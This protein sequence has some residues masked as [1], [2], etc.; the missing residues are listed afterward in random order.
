[1]IKSQISIDIDFRYQPS[2]TIVEII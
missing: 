1:L 2:L